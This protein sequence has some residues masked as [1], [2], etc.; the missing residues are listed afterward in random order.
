[1]S[2]IIRHRKKAAQQELRFAALVQQSDDAIISTDLDGTVTSWNRGAEQTYGYSAAEA[3]GRH[4]SFCYPPE[5]RTKVNAFLQRIANG[6]AIERFDTQRLKKD[7]TLIDVSLSVSAIEDETGKIVGVS[8]IARDVTARR[9]TAR[10]LQ[11][12]SAAL[13]AAANGIV[14]TDRQGTI[15]WAN[16]SFTRMTGY[17]NQEIVGK[18]P[19]L[20]KSEEQPDSCYAKL[21]STISSGK[22][23]Q[24]EIVNRRKDGTT[25]TEEMT[26]TPVTQETGSETDTYFIAIKRDITERKKAEEELQRLASIVEFSE[27]AIIGKNIDGVITSW[28]RGAEKIYGYTRD[29]VVGRDLSF[30]LPPERQAEIQAIMERVLSGQS[31][32]CLETQR[33]TRTGSAID[34]SLSVSPIKDASGHIAGASTIARDITQ[35]K[36]AEKQVQFLAYYDALTG[37]PNR[38]LLQDRLAKALASARRQKNKVA[39]L[40]LD[41]DRFKTINDSLGHSVGDLVLQQ[42]AER[43]KK[44]GR[45]QDTVARVGGDEFLIVLTAVKEPADAAVAAE[46]L[47]DTMTAEFI[48]Q[49]RSLSISCSIGI[50]IFPEHG[51]DGET[52][53]KNADAAMYCAKEN[54]RNNFQFF[55]K[56]MNAQAVERLMMES[57]LRLALAKKE[58]FL[59][60]QPQ[61]EIATGRITGLEALLR[62]QHPELGLVPPDKFIRIAENSGMIMPIGEWVLRTACSQAR[63]WQDEGFLAVPV[64]VNVS[65]VQ[66]RQAGFC[67]LIGRVLYETGL[68]PQYLELELTESLLLSNAD[69]MFSVLQDLRAMGLKL[70]IDDFGTGYSSLSYLRQFPVGKLKI[71]RSFIR[72]VVVNPDDAAIATAIIGMAK[73]LNLKVIA[74]GVEE[75]AQMSFLRARQCDEIQGYYFSKPLAVDKVA[76]KLRGDYPEG[77]VRAQASGG[78]S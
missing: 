39:L 72:D 57:G 7:G 61:I 52:L 30:L 12:Q 54:G 24:G 22:V 67:E 62:W 49:G 63:K 74:E 59:M 69:T 35:R 60:Y 65:A 71:D 33:L 1:M 9:R 28:N 56:E 8:G 31:I 55:T 68:D 40:F 76:E 50:G 41:L 4:I 53:I 34:V 26:I 23:W 16:H 21:W 77:L 10:Q 19:R 6:E 44:W 37:L 18:N 43:L 20:L 29:E 58:L 38:T 15:V 11:L 47:M 78:Q 5:R 17:S 25:Y 27:D 46:R 36:V 64:A 13:E 51:T 14:I 73:S 48:A 32:E 75:E 70:A 42:V 2:S 66:F 45:E 3:L